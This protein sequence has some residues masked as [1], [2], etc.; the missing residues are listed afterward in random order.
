MIVEWRGKKFSPVLVKIFTGT[1]T[2]FP[3]L[4]TSELRVK[5]RKK[6]ICN[7]IIERKGISFI[8]IG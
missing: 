2:F 7:V 8:N 4:P 6:E 5:M 3:A 1:L